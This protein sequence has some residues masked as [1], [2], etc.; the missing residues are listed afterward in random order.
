M[1]MV[2]YV[3]AGTLFISIQCIWTPSRDGLEIM[4]N[5]YY[6]MAGQLLPFQLGFGTRLCRFQIGCEWRKPFSNGFWTSFPNIICNITFEPKIFHFCIRSYC[7]F[8]NHSLQQGVSKQ[9]FSGFIWGVKWVHVRKRLNFLF[10]CR[11]MNK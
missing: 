8:T 6:S 1:L 11:F 7:K 5:N 10:T 4:E 9:S 3:D 2:N